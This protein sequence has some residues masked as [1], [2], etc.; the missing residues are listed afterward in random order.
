M[1]NSKTILL[2]KRLQ[3]FIAAPY[4]HVRDPFRKVSEKYDCEH[5]YNLQTNLFTTVPS[6]LQQDLESKIL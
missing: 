3:E 4:R 5:L 1:N 6:Q 2:I